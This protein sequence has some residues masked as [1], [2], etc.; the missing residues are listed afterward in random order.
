MFQKREVSV[1]EASG[2]LCGE[3]RVEGVERGCWDGSCGGG[4]D[5]AGGGWR[6]EPADFVAPGDEGVSDGLHG[7]A[8]TCGKVRM[9]K[10]SHDGVVAFAIMMSIGSSVR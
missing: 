4:G 7:E 6:G 3:R 2:A 10:D 1:E 8:V 5:V 9:K